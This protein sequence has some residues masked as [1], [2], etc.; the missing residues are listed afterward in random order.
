MSF[1]VELAGR[2]VPVT[3]WT[4]GVGAAAVGLYREFGAR[5]LTTARARS[6]TERHARRARCARLA[7]MG[8][9]GSLRRDGEKACRAS[10][11]RLRGR[12][13]D[14]HDLA[15]RHSARAS[16]QANGSGEPHRILGVSSS[17]NHHRNGIRDRWR[18]HSCCTEQ[19]AQYRIQARPSGSAAARSGPSAAT[20]CWPLQM[21]NHCRAAPESNTTVSWPTSTS[22]YLRSPTRS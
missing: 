21:M 10:R 17:G 4:K 18:Q 12:Q 9:D 8:R 16:L 6:F 5:V 20:G 3:P 22:P 13:A 1:D 14:H 2:R 15:R 19:T 7:R 11:H